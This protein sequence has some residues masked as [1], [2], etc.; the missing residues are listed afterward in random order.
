M[1][2]LGHPN[3]ARVPVRHKNDIALGQ[4]RCTTFCD[5]SH[6]VGHSSSEIDCP[7]HLNRYV[8]RSCCDTCWIDRNWRGSC[9]TAVVLDVVFPRAP[10][11][12]PVV[13]FIRVGAG[14][15]R[16]LLLC[17]GKSLVALQR[18]AQATLN[19]RIGSL[20]SIP[21]LHNMKNKDE[22]NFFWIETNIFL[23]Q[24]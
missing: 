18:R 10:A 14:V 19:S 24:Q 2:L 22:D 16:S 3:R 5:S 13:M 9:W 21:W 17:E 7:C 23:T 8:K 20:E 4:Q 1:R 12:T 6:A 11:A 15:P